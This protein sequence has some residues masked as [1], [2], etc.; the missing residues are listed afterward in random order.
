[1]AGSDYTETKGTLDFGAG[2]TVK[3]ITVPITDDGQPETDEK[4]KLTLSNP[5]AGV[6]L[7]PKATATVT[8]LDTTGMVAHR[9]DSIAV[10]PDQSVQLTLGGG[11]HKRFK[12]Y[13][14]LYPIE[15][16]TNLVDWTPLVTLLR[17]NSST[18][19]LAYTDTDAAKSD[20]KR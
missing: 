8:I 10:L 20:R 18:N 14:D 13:F 12:G 15:V 19:T 5:S 2:E 4:F 16:S 3:T 7:G 17:T 9:F 11:V 1:M 6:V